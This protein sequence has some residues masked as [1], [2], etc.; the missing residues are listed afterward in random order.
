RLL[1]VIRVHMSLVGRLDGTDDFVP[2][3]RDVS[4]LLE[5]LGWNPEIPPLIIQTTWSRYAHTSFNITVIVFLTPDH[6][7]QTSVLTVYLS[8]V[9]WRTPRGPATAMA[10]LS[11]SR[12]VTDLPVMDVLTRGRPFLGPPCAQTVPNPSPTNGEA[13][14]IK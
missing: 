4:G 9:S 2:V 12:T 3:R 7:R 6:T 11:L 5:R 10:T 13:S 1:A 8:S 14:A